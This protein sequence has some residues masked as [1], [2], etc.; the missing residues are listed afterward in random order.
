V[1]WGTGLNFFVA[2]GGNPV[3]SMSTLTFRLGSEDR[4]LLERLRGGVRLTRYVRRLVVD[5]ARAELARREAEEELLRLRAERGV[6]APV[7]SLPLS[8][9][10]A[11]ARAEARAE[12]ERQGMLMRGAGIDRAS[13]ED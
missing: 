6:A 3:V 13:L 9:D 4:A 10:D 1:F 11:R 8:A 5:A 7:S 12:R 2:S